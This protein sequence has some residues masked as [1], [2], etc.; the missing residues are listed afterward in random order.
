MMII[1]SFLHYVDL[2]SPF[3]SLLLR[4][5]PDSSTAMMMKIGLLLHQYCEGG[6]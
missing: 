4:S 2:Y 1:P 6:D 5:A 3:S